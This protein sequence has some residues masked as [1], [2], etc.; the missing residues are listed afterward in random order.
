MFKINI[1][2]EKKTEKVFCFIQISGFN[3]FDNTCGDIK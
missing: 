3:N 2:V 1:Y